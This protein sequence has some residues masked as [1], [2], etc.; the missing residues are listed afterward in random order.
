MR[1]F[2]G[3]GGTFMKEYHSLVPKTEPESEYEDRITL[4][5]AYHHL[6][7]YAIF[8]GGYKGGALRLLEGLVRKYG[9]DASKGK[10]EL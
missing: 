6:N 8:G 5:E 3:F 1:M 9:K 2:G 4:Y 7:H 10:G